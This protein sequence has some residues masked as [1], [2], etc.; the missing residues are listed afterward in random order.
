MLLAA[1]AAMV[2]LGL[3]GWEMA[4]QVLPGAVFRQVEAE[5]RGL[6]QRPYARVEDRYG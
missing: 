3:E 5:A 4:E 1:G 6:L 2:M